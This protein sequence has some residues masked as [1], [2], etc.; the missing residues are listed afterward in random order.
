MNNIVYSCVSNYYK[1]FKL[2]KEAFV[3]RLKYVKSIANKEM[4]YKDAVGW[5][6]ALE[7]SD[8]F[9]EDEQSIKD[10]KQQLRKEL[11]AIVTEVEN[12]IKRLA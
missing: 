6:M 10:K 9:C 8:L 1:G 3:R 2:D 5:I 12:N 11:K 4:T 7:Y